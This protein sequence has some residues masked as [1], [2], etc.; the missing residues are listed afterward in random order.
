[1]PSSSEVSVEPPLHTAPLPAF[2]FTRVTVTA[3]EQISPSFKRVTF[4]GVALRTFGNP[5]RILDQRI[6]LIFPSAMGLP[7]LNSTSTYAEWTALSPSSRGDMR[8]YSIRDL[9]VGEDGSSSLVIDFAHGTST[10]EVG[11]AA[12]WVASAAPGQQLLVYGPRRGR[13]DGGGIEYHPGDAQNILI[14]GDETAVPA[15]SRILEETASS[16]ANVLALLEVPTE[17]DFLDLAVGNHQRIRWLARDEREVGSSVTPVILRHLGLDGVEDVT[18]QVEDVAPLDDDP[19][20]ET[21]WFSNIEPEP[22]SLTDHALRS[23]YFWIAGESRMVT[24]L[25]RHL[26]RDLAVPRERV[27]FMGY[28]RR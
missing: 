18:P 26:V 3:V 19:V 20:W 22:R 17:A 1:M 24:N 15:I 11:P 7:N 16:P 21:A 27:A 4:G 23:H 13:L 28:W 25:R 8:T 14:V 6:K 5:H 12:R 10:A 9:V 2:Q